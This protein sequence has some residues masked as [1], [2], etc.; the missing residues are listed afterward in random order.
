MLESIPVLSF[1]VQEVFLDSGQRTQDA[2]AQRR[3][4]DRISDSF[5][6]ARRNYRIRRIENFYHREHK[7][8]REKSC[9]SDGEI[10]NSEV[11]L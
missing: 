3:V 6:S 11:D 4:F 9:T 10:T 7:E 8:R 5:A 1:A 2:G